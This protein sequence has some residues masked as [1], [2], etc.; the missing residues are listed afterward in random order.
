MYVGVGG[1]S[2]LA[3]CAQAEHRRRRYRMAARVIFAMKCY[4]TSFLAFLT[5]PLPTGR[6]NPALEGLR[7]ENFGPLL[8]IRRPL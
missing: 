2:F 4:A 5:Q 3:R 8:F 1:S 7:P 6:R